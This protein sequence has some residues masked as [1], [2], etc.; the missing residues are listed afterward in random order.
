GAVG[1]GA[2][3]ISQPAER[4]AA[5]MGLAG[6]VAQRA[7]IGGHGA[8]ARQHVVEPTRGGGPDGGAAAAAVA[9]AP[10][11]AAEPPGSGWIGRVPG[12][13]MTGPWYGCATPRP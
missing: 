9:L 11:A 13:V 10:P 3:G 2:A 7:A 12:A 4:G 6:S 1:G 5:G 8:G